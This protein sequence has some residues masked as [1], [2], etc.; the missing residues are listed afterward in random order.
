MLESL[1]IF[2]LQ[3][4][5]T[6]ISAKTARCSPEWYMDFGDAI[7]IIGAAI[8]GGLAYLGLQRLGKDERKKDT[9]DEA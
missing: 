2:T 7:S 8:G 1:G 3:R 9:D 4:R 5:C 6:R